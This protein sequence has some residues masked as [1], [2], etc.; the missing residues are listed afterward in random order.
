MSSCGL[1]YQMENETEDLHMS[2]FPQNILYN[3][4]IISDFVNIWRAH[5]K[6][7]TGTT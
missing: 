2:I 6:S 3:I 5:T 4:D 1:D 7:T